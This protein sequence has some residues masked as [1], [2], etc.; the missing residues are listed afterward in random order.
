MTELSIGEKNMKDGTV[1]LDDKQA[2]DLDGWSTHSP[3]VV[4]QFRKGVVHYGKITCPKCGEILLVDRND[5]TIKH[6]GTCISDKPIQCAKDSKRHGYE[7]GCGQTF[8][9]E[10]P[11]KKPYSRN[12]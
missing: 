12:S 7:G 8:Q 5:F 6:D 4:R 1:W 3:K 10:I 11:A 2:V 9:V